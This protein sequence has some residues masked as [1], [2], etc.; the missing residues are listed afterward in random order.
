MPVDIPGIP[1]E[2]INRDPAAFKLHA[3]ILLT[4]FGCTATDGSGGNDGKYRIGEAKVA[5]LPSGT[6]NDIITR[7]KVAL[8]F[9]DSGGPAF[10]YLDRAK[11]RRVQISVNS[12]GNIVDESH[13]S[14][15]ST[16]A[17]LTFFQ[18]WSEK[19]QVKLCGLHNDATGCR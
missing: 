1:Y 17:A 9:G 15:T 5:E 13:L 14:S 4:G 10:L 16:Q 19:N 11:K 3:E 18:S 12:R 6:N 7:G 2:R 8:C